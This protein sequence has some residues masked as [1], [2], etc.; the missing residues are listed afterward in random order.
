M[1]LRQYQPVDLSK[2]L[3]EYDLARQQAQQAANAQ[4]Q[5]NQDAL[6]REY[7]RLGN[8]NSGSF[9]KQSA[10]NN[11]QSDQN[12]S[13]AQLGITAQESAA[14]RG[15]AEAE[16]QRQ[17]QTSERVG[18][19]EFQRGILG[20]QQA[21]GTSERLGG[22]QFQT[23]L[24][25]QQQ[26]FAAGESAL[27]RQ[28]QESQFGR[29]FGLQQL[30]A[31]YQPGPAGAPGTTFDQRTKL[32]QLDLAQQQYKTDVQSTEFNKLQA[33][34]QLPQSYQQRQGLMAIYN[35]PNSSQALKNA[36]SIHLWGAIYTQ[37][38]SAE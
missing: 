14:K 29:S 32:A 36:A 16:Q 10:L 25:G 38:Q 3:P 20:Q 26:Q 5:G 23:G 34:L 17:F 7:S 13:Q 33:V 11:D 35:D 37:A 31:G 4:K 6:T 30:E 19:Q 2:P 15:L 28:L 21:Y 1:G 12:L 27:G 24:V 18:G 9:I 22:Q 8:L